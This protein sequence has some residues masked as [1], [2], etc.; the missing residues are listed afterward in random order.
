MLKDKL[1]KDVVKITLLL[2]MVLVLSKVSNGFIT[3][4]VGLMGVYWAVTNDAGKALSCFVFMPV[5]IL[6]SYPIVA[7]SN[8]HGYAVRIFPLIIA[9][10]LCITSSSRAGNHMLPFSAI[11]F[12]LLLQCV[13]S[14]M[15]YAPNVSYLKLVNFILFLSGIWIG[16]RN[17][18]NRSKD[19][20]ILRLSVLAICSLFVFGGLLMLPFPAVS[21]CTSVPFGGEGAAAAMAA[22]RSNGGIALFSGITNQSQA[23]APTLTCIIGFVLADMLFVEKRPHKYHLILLGCALV[24][25]FM[26]RSRT[27]LFSTAI[28]VLMVL[29]FAAP[30]IK[31]PTRIKVRIKRFISLGI[32]GF[33]ILGTGLELTNRTFTRW[34]RKTDNIYDDRSMSEALTDSRQGLIERSIS[35]FNYNR[36]LGCG[37]QVNDESTRF[38]GRGI[39]LSAPVEKGFL[40]LM[41]L[42]EGGIIGF[43]LFFGFV[44]S[45]YAICISKKYFVTIAMFTALLATNMGEATFFSPGGIGSILW[46]IAVVGGFTLDM[47]LVNRKIQERKAM[48]R[49]YFYQPVGYNPT[50]R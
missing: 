50:W 30:K 23:Y 31:L 11:S 2:A 3:V 13:S 29:F 7:H 18:H 22:L 16:T 45:F 47:I 26:T 21:Y 20:N 1:V 44:I 46:M 25:L 40:P 38:V 41:V 8:I 43:I 4:V 34:L 9:I 10:C 27:G 15:G 5:F 32:F 24:S 14:A 17:L 28:T 35:E 48:Q 12:Y 19:L 37:F 42:G 36:M 33:V 6:L 49:M 39:V